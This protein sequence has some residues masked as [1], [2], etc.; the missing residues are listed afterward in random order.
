MVA[1][2]ITPHYSRFCFTLAE[3]SLKRGLSLH[4]ISGI[5]REAQV[6][7][8]HLVRTRPHPFSYFL[9]SAVS[10]ALEAGRPKPRDLRGILAETLA[11]HQAIDSFRTLTTTENTAQFDDMINRLHELP[12][13]E[14]M[15]KHMTEERDQMNDRMSRASDIAHHLWDWYA[16]IVPWHTKKE[17]TKYAALT[18]YIVC[19]LNGDSYGSHLGFSKSRLAQFG[20]W[21][22]SGSMHFTALSMQTEVLDRINDPDMLLIT[23]NSRMNVFEHLRDNDLPNLVSSLTT[24]LG[25]VSS[26]HPRY[27][28]VLTTEKPPLTIEHEK[29]LKLAVV[30]ECKAGGGILEEI[31]TRPDHALI[32]LGIHIDTNPQVLIDNIILSANGTSPFLRFH[33]LISNTHRPT[34]QEID[35][36]I[37]ILR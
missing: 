13:S 16:Q 30:A 18:Y 35:Q 36:Y 5:L 4:E 37:A 29:R 2:P 8:N 1:D 15:Q 9:L 10:E 22:T 34:E 25:E 27:Y 28:I 14:K 17:P 33:F 31:I 3:T 12:D 20:G 11:V 32:C 24:P 6:V 21:K 7:I 23:P 26:E 19:E